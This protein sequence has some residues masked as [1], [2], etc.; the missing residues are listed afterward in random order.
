MRPLNLALVTHGHHRCVAGR[1]GG[2]HQAPLTPE[3]EVQCHNLGRKLA[4]E[5]VK[6]DVGFCADS[7]QSRQTVTIL[8]KYLHIESGALS[9]FSLAT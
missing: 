1:I 2:N 6:F 7:T 5:F 9:P 8:Q 3:G 4:H